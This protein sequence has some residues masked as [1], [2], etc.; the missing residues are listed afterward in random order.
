MSA[1]ARVFRLQSGTLPTE[2][3]E[4]RFAQSARLFNPHLEI[5]FEKF[6]PEIAF[7]LV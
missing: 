6:T 1:K 7:K 4:V 5:W 3:S 2:L